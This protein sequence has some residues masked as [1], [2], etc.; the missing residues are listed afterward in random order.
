MLTA[1]PGHTGVPHV[2]PL[3]LV[4]LHC[5]HWVPSCFCSECSEGLQKDVSVF[6]QMGSAPK[7]S[8]RTGCSLGF[9]SETLSRRLGWA[10]SGYVCLLRESSPDFCSGSRVTRNS[11]NWVN[12]RLWDLGLRQVGSKASKHNCHVCCVRGAWDTSDPK[13]RS[14]RSNQ[15]PLFVSCLRDLSVCSVVPSWWLVPLAA[16]DEQWLKRYF[17][18]TSSKR[19]Y[20]HFVWTLACR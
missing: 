5:S 17:H 2:C 6:V 18:V 3:T 11:H 12:L 15:C 14:H 1:L 10:L 19:P 9:P 8:T 4:S 7:R 20:S 16:S 13:L